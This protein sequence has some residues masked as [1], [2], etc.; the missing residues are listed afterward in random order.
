LFNPIPILPSKHPKNVQVSHPDD[1][2]KLDEGQFQHGVGGG[3]IGTV[4]LADFGLSKV[5]WD[6]STMTPCGTVGYTAPE[7]IRDQKYSKAVDMWAMGCVLYTLLCGFP[8]FYDESIKTLTEKVARG[9]YS[10][11]SPWWD[12]ISSSSKDLITHLLCI[13]P[14]ERYTIDEFLQHPW[15]LK[16]QENLPK[17]QPQPIP[18]T[19]D[20]P[21]TAN[22][23]SR[24]DLLSPG[25]SMKE[26]FD[27]T[28]AVQR[29]GEEKKR[30][31]A[32]YERMGNMKM[33]DEA[34]EGSAGATQAFQG[35]IDSGDDSSSTLEDSDADDDFDNILLPADVPAALAG[36][37]GG[38]ELTR[39]LQ[40]AQQ[41]RI[42]RKVA[43]QKQRQATLVASPD[44][45]ST[46]S[47]Y[48]SRRS[49]RA[50]FDLNMN[51]ATLLMKRHISPPKA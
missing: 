7:I 25:V 10:F 35:S 44:T 46:A 21:P 43:E 50:P 19:V 39:R 29:M 13:D 27:V 22:P 1:A 45:Q 38:D 41:R 51:N 23:E 32:L 15:I 33:A 17:E 42:A 40:A 31:K 2:P 36:K 20:A 9:E 18:V 24:K 11:L 37:M 48:N 28:Y 6:A 8:P 5:I 34:T 12:D 14:D 49:K 47:S 4:K 26:V 3:G 16:G 30:R